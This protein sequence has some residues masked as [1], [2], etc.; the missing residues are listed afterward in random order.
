[1]RN[2]PFPNF[3][4][5][6]SLKN[7]SDNFGAFLRAH[8]SPDNEESIAKNIPMHFL[9]LY[10]L[11]GKRNGSWRIKYRGPSIPDVYNRN[12]S[13]CLRKYATSFA[14]YKNRR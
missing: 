3:I 7:M 1:M 8:R 4:K 10:Y 6:I 9:D 5:G 13:H 14:I 2:T 12:Q 11:F